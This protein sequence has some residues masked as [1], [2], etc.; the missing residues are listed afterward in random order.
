[1]TLAEMAFVTHPKY[2][3][4]F[5]TEENCNKA[6]EALNDKRVPHEQHGNEV[7]FTKQCYFDVGR[8]TVHGAGQLVKESIDE[9]SKDA[10]KHALHVASNRQPS[11]DLTP[12]QKRIKDAIEFA[13]KRANEAVTSHEAA[14]LSKQAN[15]A[16]KVAKK[17]N[18]Q[19]THA[20]AYTLHKIAAEH[21]D[22]ES[23]MHHY[24]QM[25]I[26]KQMFAAAQHESTNEGNEMEHEIIDEAAKGT[27][28]KVHL[29]F[30]D[31]SG[32]GTASQNVKL[33]APSK[34]HAKRYAAADAMERGKKNVKAIRATEVKSTN[35]GTEMKELTPV[36]K[37]IRMVLESF[38]AK[39]EVELDESSNYDHPVMHNGKEIGGVNAGTYQTAAYYH[40][41]NRHNTDPDTNLPEGKTKEEKIAAGKKWVLKTHLD[42][43]KE[44]VELDEAK[45]SAALQ[46]TPW[47]L[48]TQSHDPHGATKSTR[49]GEH[50]ETITQ[51]SGKSYGKDEDEDDDT[52][53]P[54]F[55]RPGSEVKVKRGRG[56]PAGAKSGARTHGEDGGVKNQAIYGGREHSVLSPTPSRFSK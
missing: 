35:E 40:G 2:T 34:E 26:H 50:G 27:L 16:S 41:G 45:I 46:G 8:H 36:Q 15:D 38:K 18:S 37:R 48:G 56:R 30:D 3:L 54:G 55:K 42:A 6:V 29:N 13:K 22:L 25:E 14:L 1:M 11:G 19:I 5:D 53:R 20:K 10:E 32:K 51:V 23:K 28:H 43:I 52:D 49:K 21:G 44:S 7:H 39:Q 17:N 33:Y 31:P 47:D 4:C 12:A 24:K 9:D